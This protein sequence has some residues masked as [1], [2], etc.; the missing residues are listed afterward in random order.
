MAALAPPLLRELAGELLGH[1]PRATDLGR[2][3]GELDGR[4]RDLLPGLPPPVLETLLTRVCRMPPP[5]AS[6]DDHRTP[7]TP[8]SPPGW[9]TGLLLARLGRDLPAGGA[10]NRRARENRRARGSEAT[11][12]SRRGPGGG[13]RAGPGGR[14]RSPRRR[15]GARPGTATTQRSG[16]L[17]PRADGPHRARLG[18]RHAR[19]ARGGTRRRAGAPMADR[20]GQLASRVRD[21]LA[22]A[23]GATRT[24][25]SA[26]QADLT[27]GRERLARVQRAAAA[28]P[29]R[30]GAQRDRRIAEIDARYST[31][32]AELAR[33]AADAA[34][35]EAPGCAGADWAGWAPTPAAPGRAA[36]RAAGRHG[37][38]STAS[39]RCPRWCR[40]STPGTSTSSGD[41]RA[42]CDAVVS[43]VAAAGRR[44][45]RRRGGT[46]DRLR[47]GP[48]RRRAG[49]VRPA[50]HGRAA[51]LR[52][53]GRAGPRCS[54]T[55]WSRS[56]G[57]TRRCSPASTRRCA[58]WPRRP[59]DDPS[60]GGWRC[61]SAGRS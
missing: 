33:R 14:A 59:A 49:R 18:C 19:A 9:L 44:P 50:G 43:G 20:R 29:E 52:R 40:C 6:G 27:A 31:R 42:G 38:G 2:L 30:V 8:R 23:L 60:R 55:W 22:E 37:R 5:R 26:A 41:D 48:A 12:D 11:R 10:R 7:P 45:R 57:S 56:A 21:T 51:H 61:C 35:Q 17:P 28:V 58:N 53:P 16:G 39:T 24:R 3:R 1:P 32:I 13:D 36:R 54:T 46:P 25:L 34:R 15:C 4:V 47:P